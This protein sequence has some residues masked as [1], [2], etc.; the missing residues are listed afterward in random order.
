MKLKILQY[1]C[2]I[3]KYY[4][5]TFYNIKLILKC[6]LVKIPLTIKLKKKQHNYL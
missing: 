1:C 6:R 5:R 2:W 3:R 4:T